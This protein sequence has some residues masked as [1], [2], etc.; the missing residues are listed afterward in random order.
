MME[1]KLWLLDLA[2]FSADDASCLRSLLSFNKCGGA[3][4]QA[5]KNAKYPEP[6]LQ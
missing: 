5:V 2:R 3:V 6:E 4:E 1:S